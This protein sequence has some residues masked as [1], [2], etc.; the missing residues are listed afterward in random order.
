MAQALRLFL[1]VPADF[2][3]ASLLSTAFYIFTR[4]TNTVVK[5]R[6]ETTQEEIETARTQLVA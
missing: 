6:D 5:A 4:A 2:L 1:F 3:H